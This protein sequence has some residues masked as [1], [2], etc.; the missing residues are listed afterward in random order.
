MAQLPL[1]EFERGIA[2]GREAADRARR[3]LAAW[4]EE[5]PGQML[6]VGLAA[7]FLVGK[8]LLRKPRVAP[9]L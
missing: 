6:L 2:A 5:N 9:A 3:G 8:L 7:G 4:A 1:A